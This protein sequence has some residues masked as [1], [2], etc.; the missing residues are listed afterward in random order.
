M[1]GWSPKVSTSGGG[2]G[3]GGVIQI[4]GNT[5]AND[6]S[7]TL[8]NE[9]SS[10]ATSVTT[11]IFTYVV[12]VSPIIHVLRFE[13]GGTNIG[14]YKLY[15]GAT[16]QAQHLTWWNGPGL[17][18]MWDFSVS[19]G[20]GLAVA[21]GTVIKVKVTH[22]RPYVGDFYTRMSGLEIG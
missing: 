2:G 10:V 15:F 6:S 1:P 4:P 20:G 9:V 8:Y 19:G 18:G 21:S 11:D 13:F 22:F 14:Q 12:P 16:V 17:N 3:S 7:F 5:S